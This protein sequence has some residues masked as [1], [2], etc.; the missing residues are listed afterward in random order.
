MASGPLSQPAF[1]VAV[2]A[3]C[4]ILLGDAFSPSLRGVSI[5]C[6]SIAAATAAGLILLHR[7]NDPLQLTLL[8]GMLCLLL[9]TAKIGLD[10]ERARVV[11]IVE[12]RIPVLYT[13]TINGQPAATDRRC[14]FPMLVEHRI[15]EG[16]EIPFG[17]SAL[18][19]IAMSSRDTLPPRLRQGD[20]VALRGVVERLSGERNPG[21][22]S[23]RQYYEAN[24][25][26]CFLFVRGYGNISRLDSSGGSWVIRTVV[27]PAR[28]FVV[29]LIDSGV[30]GSEGEF[31]KGILL[32]ERAGMSSEIRQAF[33]SSGVA[34]V[35]AVSG[36]NVVVVLGVVFLL[37]ELLRLP[38]P[39]RVALGA[40]SLLFYML[41][42]GS[43]PPVVRATIM[44][45]VFL[46]STLVQERP[47]SYNA[48]G[49]S[50]LIILGLD[51]RQ[52]FDV[53]FQL[54]FGAVLSIIC[55]YPTVNAWISRIG[56]GSL[57]RRS[58]L[59]TLRLC[60]VSAVASLGTLP[61]MALSFGQVSIVGVGANLVVI[62][63]VGLSVILG[64]IPLFVHPLW[65]WLAG[66]YASLN[67]TV[68]F[69][70]LEFVSRV[71]NLPFASL[72]TF[73]FRPVDALPFYAALVLL[74][75]LGN[76][77]RV[78][79][80]LI[81]LLVGANIALV[82]PRPASE[83]RSRERM[84]VTYLDVGQ[85]DAAVV[86]FP[87]GTSLVIDAGPRQRDFDAGARVVA[88]FLLRRGIKEIDYLCFSHLH[89]DHIGGIPALLDRFPVGQVIEP[90]GDSAS[91]PGNIIL[92]RCRD[93]GVPLD[94]VGAGLSKILPG[95]AR[96][97]VLAPRRQG[98]LS[99][100]S[101]QKGSELN[102]SL[103][104]KLQFG[105]V[106]FLFTGDAGERD[107]RLTLGRYGTFL[108]ASVFKAGH[109]GSK[110]S[111]CRE[112]VNAVRPS[113]VVIS[114]GRHNRFGHP[115]PATLERL[116]EL[117]VPLART[118]EEGAVMFETDGED[119]RRVLWR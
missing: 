34:H 33:V 114:V 52:L 101:V 60:A 99:G 12:D 23:P 24:G 80:S 87:G 7:R 88:P 32:G 41:I 35:L 68:L 26:A 63:A 22:F 30:G 106:S 8:T 73:R 44:A 94:T 45:L 79:R 67:K 50:A 19:T 112:F 83:V 40:A 108:H 31:L 107:E 81:A 85:G 56:T 28:E 75:S 77:G 92:Q 118:D 54:S 6:I 21:E 76:G 82:V 13:G 16:R 9:G 38:V 36:S 5:L 86:E 66:V 2:L 48:L 59:W 61:L 116:G 103:V 62:P 11:R 49:I 98:K 17:A 96:L 71:G 115:A 51:A 39:L 110:T 93:K 78:R 84:R 109:H 97:Y 64:M 58:I 15:E 53:G 4:G 18:V 29:A 55:M 102:T 3:S 69:L 25:I 100:H 90:D 117:K 27:S 37:L 20:V 104:L 46:A 119:L 89:S 113:W 14:R 47:N 42:T 95:G 57:W 43:Q 65:P 10:R 105:D 74:L 91:G 111:N 70:T 72:E 1:K